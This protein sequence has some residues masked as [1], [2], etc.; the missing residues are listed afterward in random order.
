MPIS[1]LFLQDFRIGP[2]T[3]CNILLTILTEEAQSLDL[4]LQ[5]MDLKS[6]QTVNGQSTQTDTEEM[7]TRMAGDDRYWVRSGPVTMEV[8]IDKAH[9]LILCPRERITPFFGASKICG[10]NVGA[11][12]Q[13]LYH[14]MR[15]LPWPNHSK[16]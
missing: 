3:R 14:L 10:R 6:L 16:A 1:W 7:N 9:G 13:T 11:T 12:L 5:L 4:E 2:M 8:I 15:F